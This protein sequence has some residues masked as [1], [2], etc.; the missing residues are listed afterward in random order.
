MR[1]TVMSF[2]VR[3][4]LLAMAIVAIFVGSFLNCQ[5]VSQ[6]FRGVRPLTAPPI[7]ADR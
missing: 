5:I 3:E 7:A 2:T 6:A 4:A 1:F